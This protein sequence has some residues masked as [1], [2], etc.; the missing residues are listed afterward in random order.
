M[1][2]KRNII[3][4]VKEAIQDVHSGNQRIYDL[5]GGSAVVSGAF[6]EVAPVTC[7]DI[8]SYTQVLA[9]TYL[10]N[11]YWEEYPNNILDI[12]VDEI[13]SNKNKFI[14]YNSLHFSY[15]GKNTFKDVLKIEE[16]EKDLVNHKFA[17]KF[18][19]LFTQNYSGTFWS[20][21]QCVYIDVISSLAKHKYKGTFLYNVIMSSLMF[22]MSYTSQSTGH[23]AQFREL[24]EENLEDILSYRNKS[25][26][27]LFM[28]KFV[29]LRNIYN[30]DNNTDFKH[31]SITES[32][33]LVLKEIE[34]NSVV[35]ADP[36]YQFVHYSRFYHALETLIR[37]D[38]P[39]IK[40]KGRYRTDRH[41]SPFCIKTK[42]ESA[43]RSMFELT[44]SKKSHLVLSY[45]NT[46]MISIESLVQIGSEVF[47][48]YEIKVKEI[49]YKH[50]TMGRQK[51]K[52][53]NVME[54]IV[55][56]KSKT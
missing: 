42:V 4:F 20:F 41:Q 9:Q 32:Y 19:H 44:F 3:E 38:Y 50:S 17:P 30:G 40:H 31:T 45:S 53:R 26:I 51:D 5:F 22:A 46:G 34:S 12:I 18:D 33:D 25:I 8:Q 21:D 56:F 49:E 37:Y 6:R 23:Y 16:L 55:I 29:S 2:S 39:E 36:P 10:Q 52:Y 14:E 43:F 48:D 35:Y 47:K 13:E 28:Q 15:I 1:G 7:N 11:Y 54:A 24:T 27:D